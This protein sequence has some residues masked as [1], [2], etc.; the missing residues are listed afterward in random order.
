MGAVVEG[1]ATRLK[2]LSTVR[3]GK[4]SLMVEQPKEENEQEEK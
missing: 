2:P 4:A 3:I 1:K